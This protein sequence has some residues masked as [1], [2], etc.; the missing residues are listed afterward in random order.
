MNLIEDNN[1]LSNTHKQ[2]IEKEILGE[3]FPYYYTQAFDDGY[4]FLCHTIL[5]RPEMRNHN[6][7][8]SQ[9]HSEFFIDIF[10]TFCNKNNIKYSS[11]FRVAVN[12]TFNLKHKKSTTHVD[13]D[14]D[15]KQLIIYLND[16]DKKAKTILLKN[17]KKFAE[18]T[19]KK[20]KGA[21]FDKCKHYMI[22]PKSNARIIVIYT[23]I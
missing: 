16:C 12:L 18:I 10:K 7:F 15:H 13:H 21:C 23:F 22:Y 6:N 14:F 2:Y 8:N 9:K 5:Q 4:P 19:P 3:E 11:L 17:N 20:Y 1:F